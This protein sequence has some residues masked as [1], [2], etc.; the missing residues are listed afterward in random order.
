MTKSFLVA[1]LF[2]IAAPAVTAQHTMSPDGRV[3]DMALHSPA[4]VQWNGYQYIALTF[5]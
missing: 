5:L 3:Q 1:T 4:S 2:T